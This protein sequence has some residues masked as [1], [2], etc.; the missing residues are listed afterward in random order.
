MK[1][2]VVA[3]DENDGSAWR[4]TYEGPPLPSGLAWCFLET[5]VE[6]RERFSQRVRDRIDTL[7]AEYAKR[8]R[9]DLAW[10]TAHMTNERGGIVQ[11]LLYVGPIPYDGELHQDLVRAIPKRCPLYAHRCDGE[12]LDARPPRTTAVPEPVDDEDTDDGAPP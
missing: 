6:N 9:R 2:P 11:S 5:P 8:V 1:W 12:Y 7:V 4:C 3:L 10:R